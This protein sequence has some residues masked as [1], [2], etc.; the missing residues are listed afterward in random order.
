MILD[1]APLYGLGAL[2]P[3]AIPDPDPFFGRQ[4]TL[5]D[6]I[7]V[8]PPGGTSGGWGLPPPRIPPAL[9]WLGPW[10][11]IGGGCRPPRTPHALIWRGSKVLF[12]APRKRGKHVWKFILSFFLH[13]YLCFSIKEKIYMLRN[14]KI[15]FPNMFSPARLLP[16]K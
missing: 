8:P 6:L 7:I 13:V 10:E 12:S 16:T 2:Q 4:P 9:I 11:H 14:D 3:R 1:P 15:T 5:R